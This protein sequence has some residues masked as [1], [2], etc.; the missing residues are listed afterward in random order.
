MTKFEAGRCARKRPVAF[1]PTFHFPMN[2][3]DEIVRGFEWSQFVVSLAHRFKRCN[4]DH[5][6]DVG[7]DFENERGIHRSGSGF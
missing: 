4:I 7:S 5:I 2:Y 3:S 1:F 6:H